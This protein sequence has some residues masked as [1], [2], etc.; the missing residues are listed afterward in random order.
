[1]NLKIVSYKT[2]KRL[3]Q[4]GLDGKTIFYWHRN[5]RGTEKLHCSYGKSNWRKLIRLSTLLLPL[6]PA[7]HLEEFMT[8][9][10]SKYK[11]NPFVDRSV[12]DTEYYRLLVHPKIMESAK[13]NAVDVMARQVLIAIHKSILIKK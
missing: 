4:A 9:V 12:F 8:E 11:V 2:A 1:M 10:A 7:Y 5:Y 3:S 13:V 6:Y